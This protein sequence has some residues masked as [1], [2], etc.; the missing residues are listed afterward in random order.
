MLHEALYKAMRAA[1]T[2]YTIR[3]AD[4]Y[5]YM[6]L[7]PCMLHTGPVFRIQHQVLYADT[8]YNLGAVCGYCIQ[9]KSCIR[10]LSADTGCIH[11]SPGGTSV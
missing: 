5:M 6:R 7:Y 9:L 2:A 10:A 11:A 1:D 8:A 4:T 3:Y